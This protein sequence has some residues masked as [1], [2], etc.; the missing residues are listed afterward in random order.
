MADHCGTCKYMGWKG[1][2][3][4]CRHPKH[5]TAIVT[6]GKRCPEWID[7]ETKIMPGHEAPW[8][9]PVSLARSANGT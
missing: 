9:D 7:W 6:W 4:W 2:K 8:P 1:L 3:A 5:V